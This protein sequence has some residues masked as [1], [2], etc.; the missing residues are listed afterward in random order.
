LLAILAPLSIGVFYSFVFDDEEAAPSVTVVMSEGSG[1]EFQAALRSAVEDAVDIEFALLSDEAIRDAI[2]SSDADIGLILPPDFDA[3][4]RNGESPPIDVILPED[5]SIGGDFVLASLDPV[6]R[7]MAGQPPPADMTLEVIPENPDDLSIFDRIGAR[8]YLVLIS[9][10]LLIGMTGLLAIPIVLAEETEKKTIEALS[11]IASYR[12]IVAAK[13]SLGMIYVAISTTILVALTRLFPE[14][15]PTYVATV[16]ALGVTVIGFG[17]LLA[18]ILRSASQLNNWS[19][20]V[21][22]PVIAPAFLVG[23]GLSDRVE[24][25]AELFPTGAAMKLFIDSASADPVF[26]DSIKSF[27]VII[28][29]GI[30]AYVLLLWQLSRRRA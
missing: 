11:L 2:A 23:V 25:I 21:L 20:F 22:M 8:T 9:L 16:A 5:R 19:A 1:P 29:W 13:V 7:A 26:G 14:D 24:Q 15:W 4:V 10:V 30:V 27:A 28:A 6:L 18:G 12:E 17:L 3:A